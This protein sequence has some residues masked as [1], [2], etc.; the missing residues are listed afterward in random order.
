M[1]KANSRPAPLRLPAAYGRALVN[2]FASTPLEQAAL[3]A[4]AN[5]PEAAVA[6][7]TAEIE[8]AAL[9]RIVVAVTAAEGEDWPLRATQVWANAMQGALDVAARSAP[10]IGDAIAILAKYG[11]VRAP[12]LS[13][14]LVRTR[15]VERLLID[16]AI[17]TDEP[18]WRSIAYAIAFSVQAMLAQM[19]E[20]AVE[21]A[22]VTFPWRS[23]VFAPRL[24][25][26]V[27]YR[28]EFEAPQF[29]IEIPAKWCATRSPFADPDLHASAVA[30]LDQ[31]DER[32][33]GS[34]D[35]VRD[36]IRVIARQFP[37]R[38]GE[39][40]LASLLGLSRRTL[41]RK[42]AAAGTSYRALLDQ[43]LRERAAAMAARGN[44]SRA[45]MAAALGY[46]D[47]TSFSRACRRW[48]EVQ[49]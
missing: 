11:R 42:L 33:F 45:E 35:V 2:R 30:E 43:A 14:K 16:R 36:T 29:M 38:V 19:C 7:S 28:L 22:R 21:N 40:R 27:S 47:P 32:Q 20:C 3:L 46:A 15:R 25:E 49:K 34:D 39:D 4:K 9:L 1:P 13:I 24:R 18:A 17:D 48:F 37:Q 23:P 12:Y 8:V 44:M 6:S 26:A 5:V 41:V 31:A 10:T